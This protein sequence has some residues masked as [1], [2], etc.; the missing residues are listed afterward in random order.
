MERTSCYPRGSKPWIEDWHVTMRGRKCRIQCDTRLA[1]PGLWVPR[2]HRHQ[3]HYDTN[4]D[5]HWLAAVVPFLLEL[6]K[7]ENDHA[8]Y[9]SQLQAFFAHWRKL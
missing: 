7:G 2:R 4:N 3:T 5:P 6:T 9:E 1:R 8:E